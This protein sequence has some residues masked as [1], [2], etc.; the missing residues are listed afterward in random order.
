MKIMTVGDIVSLCEY[1][2]CKVLDALGN[3][4]GITK[5]NSKGIYSR[6]VEHLS[7]KDNEVLVWAFDNM[8]KLEEQ[9]RQGN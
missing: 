3:E 6:S 7:A 5:E 1:I 9:C 8:D 2:N 4:I